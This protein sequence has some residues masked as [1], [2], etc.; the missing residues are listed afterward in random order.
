[1][2]I[3]V[4]CERLKSGNLLNGANGYSLLTFPSRCTLSNM[5]TTGHEMN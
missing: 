2:H 4:A 5:V 3:Q 1:M